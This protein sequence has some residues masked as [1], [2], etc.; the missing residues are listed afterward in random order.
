MRI[1]LAL[2]DIFAP[3]CLSHQPFSFPESTTHGG[4]PRAQELLS[5][6]SERRDPARWVRGH[7]QVPKL[8]GTY[9][10]MALPASHHTCSD[11]VDFRDFRSFPRFLEQHVVMT[12]WCMT[13]TGIT[14][15]HGWMKLLVCK[16]FYQKMLTKYF[17]SQKQIS[18]IF[19]E[20]KCSKMSKILIQIRD[21]V[22]EKILFH[23]FFIFS[24]NTSNMLHP[25]QIWRYNSKNSKS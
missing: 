22:I 13:A 9:G 2:W 14:D 18:K 23:Q 17:S 1:F 12:A 8:F 24:I 19:F 10:T 25:D 6:P 4:T 21:F 16:R 20:K 11:L 3:G 15:E 7:W 5:T